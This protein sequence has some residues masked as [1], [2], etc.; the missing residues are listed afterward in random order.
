MVVL[1]LNPFECGYFVVFP[2]SKGRMFQLSPGAHVVGLLAH[3]VIAEIKFQLGFTLKFPFTV[4][5]VMFIFNT[6]PYVC[7]QYHFLRIS[8]TA[9]SE[10]QQSYN[11][12]LFAPAKC[13][14]WEL[15]II[16]LFQWWN[17]NSTSPSTHLAWKVGRYRLAWPQCIR[18]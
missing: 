15:H 8:A 2:Q 7:T 4:L 1:L 6:S 9:P 10:H 16:S 11:R 17:C 13:D 14:K 12:Q 3:I 18:L 5:L